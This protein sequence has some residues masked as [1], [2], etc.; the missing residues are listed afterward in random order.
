M[1]DRHRVLPSWM[2]TEEEKAKEKEPL[3][4]R[5]RRRVSRAAFYCMNEKELV[6]AAVSYLANGACGDKCVLNLNDSSTRVEDKTV[7]TIVSKKEKPSNSKKT[8][9]VTETLED[10]FDSDAQETT[11]VSESDLDIAEVETVPYIG[12]PPHQQA[13][14][15]RSGPAQDHSTVVNAVKTEERSQTPVDTADEDDAFRLGRWH[16][17]SFITVSKYSQLSTVQHGGREVR[18]RPST[19]RPEFKPSCWQVSTL[20]KCP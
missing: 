13:E 18:D 16:I 11:Y 8:E 10:F 1:S 17:S 15:Q 14:G 4:A 5:K 2:A 9:R 3:K 20:L 19:G 7:D 6:E 12:S